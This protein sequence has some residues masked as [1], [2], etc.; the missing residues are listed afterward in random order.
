[1]EKITLQVG[2]MSCAHCE[3]AVK[4]AL[5]ELGVKSIKA[6][7]KKNTV[8]IVFSPEVVSLD[9]IIAE[10]KSMDYVIQTSP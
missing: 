10:I 8:D 3:R 5:E 7:A 6:S 4:N 9:E 1:M 2:G